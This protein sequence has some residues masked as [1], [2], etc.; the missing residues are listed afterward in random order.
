MAIQDKEA[1]KKARAM[2]G[3]P[4]MFLSNNI[5]TLEKAS[6]ASERAQR[7]QFKALRKPSERE[8]VWLEHQDK[9]DGKAA[10]KGSGAAWQPRIQYGDN[11]KVKTRK[12]KG[13]N[14]LSVKK[15][16]KKPN[17]QQQQQPSQQ[18]PESKKRKREDGDEEKSQ[19]REGGEE[20]NPEKKEKKAP[21]KR[22][23]VRVRKGKKK[24]ETDTGNAMTVEEKV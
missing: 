7:L 23:R 1:R 24:S 3:V 18:T 2:A 11:G 13:P 21:R 22:R 12:A 19:Q 10:K 5:V 16:K 17:Q 14:P 15:K 4:I 8:Q 20:S 9:N 6:N